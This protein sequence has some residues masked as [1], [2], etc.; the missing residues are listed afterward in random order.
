MESRIQACLLGSH[1]KSKVR[2]F[3][4]IIVVLV[5]IGSVAG[6]AA[7]VL[8]VANGAS[9]SVDSSP[10]VVPALQAAGHNL[11]AVY[12]DLCTVGNVALQG[13][14]SAYDA[15]VWTARDSNKNDPPLTSAGTIPALQNYVSGGG[16]YLTGHDSIASPEDPLL[17]DFIAGNTGVGIDDD[18]ALG[19]ITDTNV[20]TMGTINL[21]GVTP[22]PLDDQDYSLQADLGP[23]AL[24]GSCD[25][26]D[27]SIIL[28]PIGAGC[29]AYV[30]V[31]S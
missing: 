19:P 23:S 25:G 31:D 3:T 14:L 22:A 10:S 11:T 4:R 6:H 9:S 30:S 13:V 8:F 27:C 15:V 26:T 24:G 28:R 12:D 16:L 29:L 17:A 5:S 7:G 2:A 18:R 21:V 1:L 20:L